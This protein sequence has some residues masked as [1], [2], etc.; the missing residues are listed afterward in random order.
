MSHMQLYG[1]RGVG[2]VG[3]VSCLVESGCV[4]QATQGNGTGSAAGTCNGL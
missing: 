3:L 2:P 4:Q 1:A